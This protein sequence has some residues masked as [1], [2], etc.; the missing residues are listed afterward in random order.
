MVSVSEPRAGASLLGVCHAWISDSR[1]ANTARQCQHA[2]AR[3]CEGAIARKKLCRGGA[4]LARKPCQLFRCLRVC[5]EHARGLLAGPS[6][7]Q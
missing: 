2:S 4:W 3:H 1:P 5:T 6:V 7:G